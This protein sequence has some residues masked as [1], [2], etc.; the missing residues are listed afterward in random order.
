LVEL[1]RG[2]GLSGRHNILG[3]SGLAKNLR[4]DGYLLFKYPFDQ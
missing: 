3:N 4:G 1:Y 2:A